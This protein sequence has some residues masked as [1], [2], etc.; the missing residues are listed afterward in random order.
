MSLFPNM[1]PE[2]PQTVQEITQ[3]RYLRNIIGYNIKKALCNAINIENVSI[4]VSDC[5]IKLKLKKEKKVTLYIYFCGN[6]DDFTE[7][8]LMV[9]K[10]IGELSYSFCF[11][12]KG[13]LGCICGGN[14]RYREVKWMFM[15]AEIKYLIGIFYKGEHAQF[16]KYWKSISKIE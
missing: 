15:V 4:K 12:N 14:V 3:N 13:I 10:Q 7:L 8:F 9:H 16:E 11:C 2:L 6:S 1:S 5:R